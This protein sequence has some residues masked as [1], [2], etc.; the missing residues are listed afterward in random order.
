MSIVTA[1]ECAVALN[2]LES[3]PVLA[4]VLTGTEHSVI[5]YLRY[6]PVKAS[7]VEFYPFNDERRDAADPAAERVDSINGSAVFY[8]EGQTYGDI[9]ILRNRPVWND[10]SLEVRE[11]TGACAGQTSGSFGSGTILTKG[12]H[13]WLDCNTADGVSMSG[14]LYR[15][16][17]NWPSDPGSIKVT[18]NGGYSTS[19]F[20]GSTARKIADIKLATIQAVIFNYKQIKLNAKQD[21]AGNTAGPIVAEKIGHYSYRTSAAGVSSYNFGGSLPAS[22]RELL[23][24]HR[25]F[26]GI[27]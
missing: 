8:Q 7:R 27:F 15:L 4:M 23:Q 9:L 22:C 18:Y 6:D 10:N 19:D 24:P 21:L 3:D 26:H 17:G 16:G 12:V 14:I 2:V 13:Y 5:N 20:A 1:A 25:S 11:Q